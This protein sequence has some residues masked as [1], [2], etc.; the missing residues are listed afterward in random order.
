MKR[1]ILQEFAT[2]D[3]FAADLNGG[4]D[5]QQ[6]YVASNDQSFIKDAMRFLDSVDTMLIGA[7]TYKFFTGNAPGSPEEVDEFGS[8]FHALS[9][10]V[11][12]S[13]L[14]SAPWGEWEAAK[15]IKN[16]VSEEVATL[17]EQS[18]KDIVI[19][20]SM[21]LARELL[22]NRLIDEIQLRVC[23][24]VLGEGKPV[25]ANELEMELLEAKTY[26]RGLVLLRYQPV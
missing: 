5:F 2:V 17:K 3:G 6:R 18:G 14:N 7:N 24:A 20:G 11:V 9:K 22:G 13:S 25:F 23:P 4:M 15:I 16:N 26:D 1:L 12:S 19:W 21:T 8:K 10:Y